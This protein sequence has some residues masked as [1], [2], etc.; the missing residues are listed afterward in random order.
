MK[1]LTRDGRWIRE[2]EK[3]FG[4]TVRVP[5]GHYKMKPIARDCDVKYQQLLAKKQREREARKQK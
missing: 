4:G 5:F 1:R 2:G 3:P